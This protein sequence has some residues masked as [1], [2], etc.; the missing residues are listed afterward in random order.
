MPGH[1]T[2]GRSIRVK[3]K[4]TIPQRTGWLL[5]LQQGQDVWLEQ[6]P[7]VGLWGGLFCFPQYATECELRLALRA[8]GVDDSKL[9]QMNAFRHTF[10]HFHLDIVP[11]W[12]DLPSARAA[13]D[14]GA[15]L[16]YNL[17]QPPSVGLAAPVDRLLQQLRQPQQLALSAGA[18]E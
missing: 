15:G 3:P 13:M 10:S 16:W 14:D 5:L 9:Q 18:T 12:L 17:A 4:Q 11:M 7:P 1:T 6:R 2:A 8:R